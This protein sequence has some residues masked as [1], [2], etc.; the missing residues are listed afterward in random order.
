M[1]NEIEVEQPKIKFP[2]RRATFLRNTHDLSRFVVDKSFINLEEQEN[3]IAK[4]ELTRQ[5]LKR[6]SRETDVT[7][8]NLLAEAS[9]S[10]VTASLPSGDNPADEDMIDIANIQGTKEVEEKATV[11]H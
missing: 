11:Q 3:N 10:S 2:D 1:I 6:I 7:H 8:T 4:E 9:A 5:E